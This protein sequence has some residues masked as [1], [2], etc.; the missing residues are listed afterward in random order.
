[1][2]YKKY[3]LFALLLFSNHSVFS[4]SIPQSLYSY[5]SEH[6]VLCISAVG[7]GLVALKKIC[8]R[9]IRII[10]NLLI[11][12]VFSAKYKC[13]QYM[14]L[15]PVNYKLRLSKQ[16]DSKI[17]LALIEKY[18]FYAQIIFKFLLYVDHSKTQE[19]FH[20][21][22]QKVY[23]PND[24]ERRSIIK[25]LF[26]CGIDPRHITSSQLSLLSRACAQKDVDMTS[27]LLETIKVS[28]DDDDRY[29]N[30]SN[31]CNLYSVHYYEGP[32]PLRLSSQADATQV[33]KILIRHNTNTHPFCD[34][35]KDK[36]AIEDTMN[37]NNREMFG[38]LMSFTLKKNGC[39]FKKIC[40]LDNIRENHNLPLD[41]TRKIHNLFIHLTV[42]SIVSQCFM[43][44]QKIWLPN[45]CFYSGRL[46]YGR[47]SRL[48]KQEATVISGKKD[49]VKKFLLQSHSL[50]TPQITG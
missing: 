4:Y 8:S 32:N 14:I 35:G 19:S 15:L 26:E 17:V 9:T 16:F 33:V 43:H 10:H 27:F 38:N 46:A 20:S 1:M 24:P 40:C 44:D 36:T 3:I 2:I 42:D 25:F 30:D 18:K 11:E 37:H 39:H 6:P 45:N 21:Y 34:I 28:P 31:G 48:D 23:K 29:I 7:I 49:A 47:L 13:I 22:I 5:A 50:P 41:I 12:K